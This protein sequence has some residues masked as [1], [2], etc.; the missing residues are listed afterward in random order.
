MRNKDSKG[1]I[2]YCL[3]CMAMGRMK[4]IDNQPSRTKQRT[5]CSECSVKRKIASMKRAKQ[6]HNIIQSKF[7]FI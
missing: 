1:M 3:D 4:P 6:R 2:M 7:N 5:Y